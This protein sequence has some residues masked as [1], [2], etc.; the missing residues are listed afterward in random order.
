ML[1]I[2]GNLLA[3]ASGLDLLDHL[4]E[5]RLVSDHDQWSILM[6][7]MKAWNLDRAK[8][9]RKHQ[10]TPKSIEQNWKSDCGPCLRKYQIEQRRNEESCHAVRSASTR[11]YRIAGWH[12]KKLSGQLKAL[13]SWSWLEIL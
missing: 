5:I 2:D 10:K 13:S 8:T 4:F 1:D 11:G 7:V 6:H 12:W 3:D 9:S